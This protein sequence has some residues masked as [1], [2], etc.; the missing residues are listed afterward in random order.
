MK[1][2]DIFIYMLIYFS[3]FFKNTKVSFRISFMCVSQF[4][5]LNA[6]PLPCSETFNDFALPTKPSPSL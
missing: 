4:K 5:T 1:R 2:R 3:V 6:D